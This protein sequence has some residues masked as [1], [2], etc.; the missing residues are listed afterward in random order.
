VNK[1]NVI[2]QYEIRKILN[3]IYATPKKHQIKDIKNCCRVYWKIN[4]RNCNIMKSFN[5]YIFDQSALDIFYLIK[6]SVSKPEEVWK[7]YVLNTDSQ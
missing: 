2:T 6:Q 7:S 1:F 5:K 4:G 3:H